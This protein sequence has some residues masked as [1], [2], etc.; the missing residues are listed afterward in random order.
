ME[1]IKLADDLYMPSDFEENHYY[2]ADPEG[3]KKYTGVSSVLDKTFGKPYLLKWAAN[4]AVEAMQAGATPD[5]AKVAYTK[6]RTESADFGTNAH[7]DVEN[8]IKRAIKEKGG[9]VDANDFVNASPQVS[10]LVKWAIEKDVVFKECELTLHSKDMWLAGTTDFVCEIGGSTFVGDLK[11]SKQIDYSYLLQCAAYSLML[12]YKIDGTVIVRCGKGGKVYD[13]KT[14]SYKTIDPKDDFEVQYRYDLE[15]D[16]TAFK[17]ALTLY[18]ARATF[19]E[20]N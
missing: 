16:Q 14:R 20:D 2:F 1:L 3:K 4:C 12:P 19:G 18:R 8:V 10:N 15:T 11:T 9:R 13:K 17:A 7:A 5:E 6:K